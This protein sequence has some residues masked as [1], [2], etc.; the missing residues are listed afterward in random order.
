MRWLLGSLVDSID[1]LTN[2]LRRQ[3]MWLRRPQRFRVF[4]LR[5]EQNM[6]VYGVSAAAPVDSDV[7]ERR[8][9]VDVVD[10][11]PVTTTFSGDTT[12]LGEIK[13]ERDAEVTLSLVDVDG[14]GNASEP[15]TF[16]FVALDTIPPATPGEFGVT[17]L[18]Q[19]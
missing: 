11:E 9:T 15:A 10:G 2:E 19:E 1:R 5:Q 8:L 3:S 17:L 13:V 6:L 7:V 14:S 4:P 16:E 12:D 18:R